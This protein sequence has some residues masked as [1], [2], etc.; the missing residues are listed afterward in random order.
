MATKTTLVYRLHFKLSV[1]IRSKGY[2]PYRMVLPI[3]IVFHKG[4]QPYATI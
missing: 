1:C 4:W 2:Q 3:A